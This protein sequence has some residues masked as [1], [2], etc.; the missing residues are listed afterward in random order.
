[1]KMSTM[2]PNKRRK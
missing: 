2:S 1:M